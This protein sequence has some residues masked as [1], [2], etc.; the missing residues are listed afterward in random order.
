M[1]APGRFLRAHTPV[2]GGLVSPEATGYPVRHEI[3]TLLRAVGPTALDAR[4]GAHRLQQCA[5]AGEARRRAR[6]RPGLGRRAP[7]PRGVLALPRARALPDRVRDADQA[8][9]RRPRHHRVRARVQPPDQG[10]GADRGA[11]HSLGRTARR[12]NGTLGDVDGAGGLQRQPRRH[13]EE[14]GRVRALPAEDVDLRAVRL[15]GRVLVDAVAHHSPQGLSAAASTALGRGDQPRHRARRRGSGHGKP[16]LDVR[17]VRRAGEEDRRVPPPH[18]ALH[19]GGRIR[20]RSGEHDQLPVLPRGRRG[21]AEP[22]A[23]NGRYVQLPRDPAHLGARDVP[24]AIVSLARSPAAASPP[25]H[26]A[27]RERA[28][29]RWP[30]PR[31]SR[32]GH[33][34]AQALRVGG[35]RPC[36]LPAQ[37]ERGH[38]AA[39]GAREPAAVRARGHARLRRIEDRRGGRRP[40]MPL[41]GELAVETVAQQLPVLTSL[42]TEAWAL[43][44]AEILQ[45]GFEIGGTTRALLPR[46][47]HPA[48]PAY[49]T[50]L[51]SRYPES[52]VGPFALAQLRLM[53]RAG[54]HPRGFVLGAVASTPGAVRAL[55]E[56]WGLP[57]VLGGITLQRYHDQVI[58]AVTREGEPVLEA[59]LIDPEPISGADV[60]YIHSVTLA[61]LED[62][63]HSAP[64]LV[65]VD[66]HYTFHKAERGRP[67]LIRFDARA[68][69][70][71]GI[72]PTDPI[73]A[74]FTACDTD[75]PQIRFVM[76]P[77]IPVV[78]GT[79]RIP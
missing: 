18:P 36:E 24:G 26:R 32:A 79:R 64:T 14:L 15:Q 42:D 17:P 33:A 77:E 53:G 67:R 50:W 35:G 47:M 8:H 65:Q 71:E 23:A 16:R 75:L 54:A 34:R 19:A 38:L 39:R 22:R 9:P 41:F 31:R 30:V 55:R 58:A 13:E 25:G 78:R 56:G 1:P 6:V 61:R 68:W 29:R 74:S 66:P 76:D 63:E 21:G 43:P 60:Q 37:R 11:R 70:A 48:I 59:A 45:L 5:R 62:G 73:A 57:A 7:L 27:R 51:V 20:E 69:Q 40:L 72:E 52:P 12:G 10:R 3:R 2:A 49:A 4:V 46:A 28:G 44:R